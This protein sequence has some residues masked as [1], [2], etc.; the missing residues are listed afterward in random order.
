MEPNAEN[1]VCGC[2]DEKKLIQQYNHFL[3]IENHGRYSGSQITQPEQA[4]MAGFIKDNFQRIDDDELPF[5]LAK[6][7]PRE[8]MRRY[9]LGYEFR[10]LEPERMQLETLDEM[11]KYAE[12]I[13][14]RYQ[15]K[16]GGK[17]IDDEEWMVRKEFGYEDE[18]SD[19]E[20]EEETETETESLICE[21]KSNTL[22]LLN[23][24]PKKYAYH[25]DTIDF[26]KNLIRH[27]ETATE[28]FDTSFGMIE[29]K[30]TVWMI[31]EINKADKK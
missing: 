3:S 15:W 30:D 20:N 23:T 28:N 26:A 13:I 14:R 25:P 5:Y 11:V 10:H 27:L 2:E 21:K 12:K 16:A 31:I 8:E 18:N 24:I 7:M 22:Y 17:Y 6:C 29:K 4:E 9:L 19:D 1:Q